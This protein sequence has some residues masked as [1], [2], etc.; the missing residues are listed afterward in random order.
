MDKARFDCRTTP[1]AIAI[2]KEPLGLELRHRPREWVSAGFPISEPHDSAARGDQERAII[3]FDK[4]LDTVRFVWERIEFRRVRFPAPH[5]VPHPN[6][7]TPFAVVIQ[8]DYVGPKTAVLSVAPDALIVNRAEPSCGNPIPAGPYRT[9]TILKEVSNPL[10]HK[11][12]ILSQLAVLPTCQPFGGADPKSPIARGEETINHAGGK[13]LIGR[14]LP[15]HVSDVIEA[16]QVEFRTQPEI[17]VGSLG[18]GGDDI[19]GKAIANLPRGVR[20]LTHVQRR[21]RRERARSRNQ[22]YAEE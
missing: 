21:I 14:R 3:A 13:R 18:N 7:D 19:F 10:S 8:S 16:K 11:F 5:A 6:P 4:T 22:E 2:P 20:V 15:V 12:G 1:C 9:C 17:A